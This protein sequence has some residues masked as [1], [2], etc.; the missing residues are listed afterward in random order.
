MHIEVL[1]VDEETF[2][3]SRVPVV[4]CVH[5][6]PERGSKSQG[7]ILP[8]STICREDYLLEFIWEYIAVVISD[9]LLS[10]GEDA[11][12]SPVL[13]C[14]EQICQALVSCFNHYLFS[15]MKL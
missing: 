9:H 14:G 11:G 1:I 4:K 7:Q 6:E 2:T 10:V 15:L 5:V 13:L 12:A 8:L 3:Y